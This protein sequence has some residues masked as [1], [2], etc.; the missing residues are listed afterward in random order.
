L[1]LN[2]NSDA[3]QAYK[4]SPTSSEDLRILRMRKHS[5]CR[6]DCH[7]TGARRACGDAGR[8]KVHCLWGGR[9]F[10]D[11]RRTRSSRLL[12]LEKEGIKTDAAA[13]VQIV[14]THRFESRKKRERVKRLPVGAQ[15]RFGKLVRVNGVILGSEV[16][17]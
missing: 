11:D 13:I 7:Q 1:K 4:L 6:R 17:G 2:A 10:V 16:I 12:Q 15:T 9:A 14:K 8:E 5:R 3:S